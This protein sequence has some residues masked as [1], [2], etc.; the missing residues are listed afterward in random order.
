MN[1]DL[2]DEI[3]I[4]QRTSREFADQAIRPLIDRMEETGEYPVPLIKEMAEIGLLGLIAPPEFGG[5][6]L[7]FLAR[8]VALQEISKVSAAIGLSLQCH[9]MQIGAI[10]EWGNQEQKEKYLPAMTRGEYLGVC[11]ITEPTGGSDL[12]GMTST[13][14]PNGAG[15]LI[16]GRKCFI[17]NSHL[18]GAP[19]VV[20]KT[21]E[22]S[23][24][25]SAFI[26][27]R[28]TEGYAT[29]RQEH[30]LGLRGS[31]TGEI[32]F[33]NCRVPRENLVGDEG[34]GMKIALKT[35]S[36]VGRPG[37]AAIALGIHE[38]CFE[39]AVKFARERSL[40]GKPIANLQAIQWGIA[41]IYSGLEA[42][43]L[44]CYRASWLKD[45]DRESAIAMTLAKTYATDAAVSAA[46]K[47][48]EIHGGCGTMMEYPIQRYFRDAM[49]CVSAGG[50]TEIGKLVLSR[51][52]LD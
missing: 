33:R 1:F 44:L 11:A 25:L 23:K 27:D 18:A 15:Y 46:R 39:E 14:I 28:A 32:F 43:R 38:A 6:G 49:V 42:S 47:S 36:E 16:T 35:I 26:V 45:Q 52:A 50:T 8:T 34:M 24:G 20:A 40:Y 41:E 13:A 2:P 3:R 19:L 4:V 29:G 5:S 22:G 10:L 48:L 7:G 17:T 12:M 37:M 30:K 9:H 21:G 31:N 51:A